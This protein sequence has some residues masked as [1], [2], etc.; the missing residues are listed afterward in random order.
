MTNKILPQPD[1]E[2]DTKEKNSNKI[3][4]ISAAVAAFLLLGLCVLVFWPNKKES[5]PAI[6]AAPDI[7]TPAA[8]ETSAAEDKKSTWGELFKQAL[9]P[10]YQEKMTD[11]TSQI[12][13]VKEKADSVSKI[14]QDLQTGTVTEKVAKLEQHVET[15]TGGSI[16]SLTGGSFNLS[17]FFNQ[18]ESLQKTQNGS[19]VM[20]QLSGL[21][22]QMMAQTAQ[23]QDPSQILQQAQATTP[24]AAQIAQTIRA[25]DMQAAALLVGFSGLRQSLARDNASF[26][27]DL[28]LL[29]KTLGASN[30]DLQAAIQRL[31]PQ[32][33]YGVLTPQGL[34]SEL[35]NLSGEIVSASLTG[36]DISIEEKAKAKFGEILQVEKNGQQISGT[37]SQIAVA[38]A[39]KLLKRGDVQGAMTTLQTLQGAQPPQSLQ[40]QALNDLLTPFLQK[41]E[42]TMLAGQVQQMA[43]QD[44]LKSL[45]T[46][47]TPQALASGALPVDVEQLKNKIGQFQPQ[48]IQNLM[49]QIQTLVPQQLTG[50]G[51]VYDPQSGFRQYN[52]PPKIGSQN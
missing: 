44:V 23:G 49:Q 35:R 4:V 42:A 3:V 41:A 32:A 22:N 5:L 40:A 38:Q 50:A 8:Q 30:P 11:L 45:Q 52:P 16:T 29:E 34:S 1:F 25:E 13:S 15:L 33:Q 19:E 31:A 36:Q 27:E 51:T 10:E 7:E 17:A 46:L 14:A 47:I 21:L 39:Q 6:V 37:D 9:P 24:E 12:E 18:I 28:A 2:L 48:D 43:G 20:T 26:A